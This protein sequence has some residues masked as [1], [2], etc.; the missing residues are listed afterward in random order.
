MGV[1]LHL[2]GD[3]LTAS[4]SGEIDHHN[5]TALREA[6]DGKVAQTQPSELVLDFSQVT[7][8]DSAG[9]GLILGRYRWMDQLGGG[10]RITHIPPRLEQ[11]LVLSGIHRL[12]QVEGEKE[13]NLSETGITGENPGQTDSRDIFSD[14]AKEAHYYGK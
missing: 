10:V 4:L 1:A 3:K 11:L 13:E 5:S 7:F 9:I 2:S 14:S 8:M 6:I 12:V